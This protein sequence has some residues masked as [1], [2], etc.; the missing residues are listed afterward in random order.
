MSEAKKRDESDDQAPWNSL[1]D[2]CFV[3]SLGEVGSHPGVTISNSLIK[4]DSLGK[5][6]CVYKRDMMPARVLSMVFLV[7]PRRVVNS[8]VILR[9]FLPYRCTISQK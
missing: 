7:F 9:S 2:M 5:L 4:S 8:Q 3:Y 1:F 6:R